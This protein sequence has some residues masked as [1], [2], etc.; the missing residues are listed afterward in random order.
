[1]VFVECHVE[2]LVEGLLLRAGGADA[3]VVVML[4]LL[5]RRVV[6]GQMMEQRGGDSLPRRMWALHR[7]V[8]FRLL[9]PI[10]RQHYRLH[11]RR[12]PRGRRATHALD[13]LGRFITAWHLIAASNKNKKI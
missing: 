1:M 3:D 5:M 4:I 9:R 11:L 12:T 13:P 6:D 7:Q 10:A 8:H 2:W